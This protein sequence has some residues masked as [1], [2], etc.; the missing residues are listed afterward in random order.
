MILEL[1]KTYGPGFSPI[2]IAISAVIALQSIKSAARTARIRATLDMIE[3]VES[4]D[5]YVKMQ[6]AFSKYR[7]DGNLGSL[8]SP[9]TKARN[10]DRDLVVAYLNHYE[11]VAIGI[12]KGA[13]DENYYGSWMKGPLVRDW[14]AAAKFIQRERWKWDASSNR[15]IYR[16]VVWANFGN[17][18]W[19]WSVEAKKLDESFAPPPTKPAGVGDEAFPKT[20][21]IRRYYVKQR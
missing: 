16:D 17:L 18:A 1:I 4:T 13:L 8:N 6:A 11:L 19:R 12:Q 7:Q 5:R 3:K 20:T 10:A 9:T 2:V 21:A 14:N 15:W